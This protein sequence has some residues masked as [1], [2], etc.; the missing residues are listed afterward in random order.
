MNQ[1]FQMGLSANCVRP[2]NISLFLILG[3]MLSLQLNAEKNPNSI[4]AILDFDCHCS[5]DLDETLWNLD[6][7][8]GNNVLVGSYNNG[9]NQVEAIQWNIDGT[10][11]YGVDSGTFGTIN[12]QTGEFTACGN[13]IGTGNGS[14]GQIAFTDIDGLAL[15]RTN[16]NLYAS[17]RV[18]GGNDL[19]LVIDPSTCSFV[20]GAFGG[21]D[22]VE[23]EGSGILEDID[24]L[25]V[26]PATGILYAA[27]VITNNQAP[28]QLI[29]IDINTGVG[30]IVGQLGD[31]MEGLTF[32]QNGNL[33]G[34]TGEDGT[35]P[36]S[37]F[38][39]DKSNASTAL[40]GTFTGGGDFEAIS[41]K[42]DLTPPLD[43]DC[44]AGADGLSENLWSFDSGNG[45][46][47]LVGSFGAD[48]DQIEAIEY[49]SDGTVIYG[50][51][52]GT[53]GT[54]DPATGA[55][56]ACGSPIGTGNGPN[57]PV[58]FTDVDGLSIMQSTGVLYGSHRS[59][60]GDDYLFQIDPA[61]C[62]FIPGV[63]AGGIDY[64]QITGAG[65]LP[66][67][68]DLAFDPATGFLY[69]GNTITN[70]QAPSQLIIIDPMTGLG[71]VVGVLSDDM[72]GLTFTQDGRLLG[73]TGEDGETPNSIWEIDKSNGSSVLIAPF[74]G[75]SDFESLTCRIEFGTVCGHVYDDT[76][77]DGD[78]DPGEPDL[79]MI[80]VII[81]DSNGISQ[82]V[83][84]D[85]DGNYCVTVPGGSTTVLVD[86]AD[87]DF[88][89]GYT[90]TEGDNPTTINVP[91]GSTTDAGNDGYTC[92]ADGG[93][94]TSKTNRAIIANRA[95]GSISVING[96]TNEVERS[97]DMLGNGEP[98]YVVHNTQSNSFL[99]G[100]YNGR[101][102][103]YGDQSLEVIGIADAGAGVFHMWLSPNNQQLWVN[104]ELDKT[105]SVI[106]PNNLSTITTI[107]LPADLLADGFKPH[108]VIVMPDN[109]AAFVT[110][111]GPLNED[112]VLKYDA[113]TF[114]EVAR[115]PVGKDPH[116]ALTASNNKLYVAS[117]ESDE[118]AVLLR[119]DLS[120]VTVLN[121][122]NAHGLGMN[123]AGT[124]LYIGN[125]SEGGTN[126]TYTLDLSNNT[127]VGSPVD[128]PFSVPHN[129]T[130][131]DDDSKL[132]VTHSSG[133]NFKVSIYSLSPTPTLIN[134]VTTGSNPFGLDSY[135]ASGEIKFCVGDGEPD[136]IPDGA[137]TLSGQSGSNSQWVITDDQGNILGLPASPY[138]VDFDGTGVGNCLVWHLSFEDGLIGATVGNNANTDLVGCYD[139]SNPIDVIRETCDGTVSGHL[140]IDTDGNGVQDPGEPDLANV[141]VIITDA[142]G[143]MQTVSTDANGDYIATVPPGNTLVDVDETDPDFPEG[144]EQTEGTDPTTVVAVTNMDTF[145]ENNGY[146][147]A[148][149]GGTLVGGPFEFCVGDGMDD[150]IPAG[151]ITLT[152][153][154]GTNSQWIVT[155]DQGVILGLP[156]MPSDVNFDGTG[157]GN[158]LV[159]H[160]SFENGLIGAAIG[161]NVSDLE[162]CYDLSNPLTIVRETCEGTVSGHLYVD[163]DG[164]GVQ[165]PGEPDLANVD[166]IIT[167]ANGVMQTV[168]TDA[169]GDYIA[170]V[171]PGLTVIDVDETDPD[172]PAGYEQTEGTDP[173]TVT[174]VTNMNVFEENNGY[175]LSGEICGHLYIDTNG[176]GM[177][178]AGEPDLVNVDVVITDSNGDQ[179]T[180]TSDGNGDYCA[181]VPPGLT[182]ADIDETD[183]D[184]P[185]GYEQTEG[186]DPTNVNVNP[187]VLNDAGNDGYYLPAEIFGHLYIDTDGNGMQD[188]GEPDL[189]NV[190]I[191]ITDSNGDMQT[192]STNANGD[193]VATVPPGSTVADVDETDSNYPTDYVQ[194]EG[195]DPTTVVA[196]A[197]DLTDA[198]NDGYHDPTSI[199]GHLYIDSNG[200]GMQDPG[201][202]NL[203][204]VDVIV[205]DSNGDMQ[206]VTTDANGDWT[207]MIP[208]GLTSAD[209][210]E[211][212]PDYPDD[213]IQTEGED[214]TLIL[215]VA[216]LANDGGID[217][218]FGN[219]EIFGHVYIDTNGDGNQ[220]AGEP[221]LPNLDVVITD[222]NGDMQTVTTDD[223]GDWVATVPPGST[224]ANVD[225]TDS[226]YPTDYVQTEGDD[227]TTVVAVAGD[228]TDAGND[229]YH[230][231][232]SIFGHL[233]I[234]S[235][236]N[237]MQDPGEPN[238]ANVDVIVTDSNGDMQTVTTDANGDWTAMIPPG[239]T[240]ANIDETDPDYPDDYIQ[241]EGDDPTLILA[242]AGLANDGGIDGYFGD[243]EIFGHVYIDTNGDG[244]QDAGEP[245]LPNLGVVITDSNG[246]TQT[247]T[248]DA[249]GDYSAT[250]PPGITEVDVIEPP[251]Y[252]QTEGIDP[253]LVTA[254]V[255]IPMDAGIDGFYNPGE[256][257]GHLYLD[258]NGNGVQDAGD[259]DL[260][261]V[262]VIITDS[263][264]DMQT[265]TTD[266]N[267][268]WVATVPPGTTS[269]DVDETDPDYPTGYEQTEGEDPTIVTAVGGITTDAG[270]DGYYEPTFLFGHLYL[271]EN[272]N[273]MQD[274]GRTRPC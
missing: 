49:S 127:L 258:T 71:S 89:E 23:I 124:Y 4:G 191:I 213:Y 204:N 94:L 263:N 12:D 236:G 120:E 153:E 261:N 56:A 268:D 197:G 129:Y 37:F 102:V 59:N 47:G 152:G 16:G 172:Y 135:C 254:V 1:Q 106:D 2:L 105:I 161:N 208:P 8:T 183:P 133:S 42:I 101:V 84:T 218:Y 270:N 64:V 145:E 91:P 150:F 88:P 113:T 234:D 34:V 58:S 256:V 175:Y 14:L 249:N 117:Q 242:V 142:N 207:A 48:I 79:A 10:I 225:E 262:D 26:D 154:M 81:T 232:T 75:D 233:Y 226:N 230:D 185:D 24:D 228:L 238:L 53:F 125:I 210:D 176:N 241:T 229:G 201:E 143:E 224:V 136:F 240:S 158:C 5:S 31:D 221:N 60:S 160:L 164:N 148:S 114:Q 69:A 27:N 222:S 257:A 200:N 203:A 235:N 181:M 93:Q 190:D 198:G 173:T 39:I 144:Y 209:I 3:L 68:D 128:A 156:G 50:V 243:A 43:P 96:L 103:A 41:C 215:A 189:A 77:A 247:V 40:M 264:G 217:G 168:T 13:T 245:N 259:P 90:Q 166:V 21:N 177:Q 57:G 51:D 74:A 194:T 266:D 76:N 126:A 251:G 239:L 78:Q 248:T 36:N 111:L 6:P 146:T 38:S 35:T 274:A 97:F 123:N 159:W 187:G 131:S 83:S 214:P 155:D 46:N 25:A 119:S 182:S 147:C 246:V 196:V 192:V 28:S 100:D 216:G 82:T 130:V 273:G 86:E 118:L 22:Y 19:L 115:T 186:N 9:V 62:S 138:D 55:F 211:T 54:L 174:A 7:T 141:N 170:T 109:S 92:S 67:I 169:N 253:S 271:D 95:S 33:L 188:P 231:P 180:V 212:D 99:V 73:V 116:V 223:N 87:P 202:P 178:D 30:S 98:M 206:T 108:D 66:D 199:F 32:R 151:S 219:A 70:N 132:F 255:G 267:G 252:I 165:D 195:D 44:Y 205:T 45:D 179:Q 265:V 171:P 112:Y 220:D 15:H 20:P 63:F 61:T 250:V 121:V 184:Y 272:N 122:P 65:I 193:W 134:S 110:V 139:L 29:T 18:V 104:N 163:T 17:H 244:N 80:D 260:A 227:P 72:E 157:V 107:D 140:Y 85:Q 162:G 137:I 237:G 269:A 167:D 11:L 52:G 149:D